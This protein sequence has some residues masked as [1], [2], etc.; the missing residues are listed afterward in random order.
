MKFKVFTDKEILRV[1]NKS[2]KLLSST[3]ITIHICSWFENYLVSPFLD[4]DYT[5]N[6]IDGRPCSPEIYFLRILN[7]FNAITMSTQQYS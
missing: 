2:G 5:V 3:A 4:I 1:F 7:V 6:W